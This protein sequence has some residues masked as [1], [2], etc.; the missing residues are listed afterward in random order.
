[1][2]AA[3][4]AEGVV[5]ALLALLVTGLLRSHAEILRALHDLGAGVQP[6]E[7]QPVRP[8]ARTST[9]T[10]ASDVAGVDRDGAAT[11]LAVTSTD[12]DTL[13]AFLSSGCTTCQPFWA[14]FRAGVEVPGDARLVVVTQ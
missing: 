3:V 8:T 11:A 12:H 9:A 14:A 2:L 7:P 4:I 5:V 1:M 10:A 6:D 13:L